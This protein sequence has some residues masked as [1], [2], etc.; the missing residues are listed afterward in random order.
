MPVTALTLTPPDQSW[1]DRD[2][3]CR[4]DPVLM[5]AEDGPGVERARDVCRA[6]PV[7]ACC[8]AWT[9]SLPPSKDVAGV[10]GGL[11]VE[12]RQ[13]ARR[14]RLRRRRGVPRIEHGLVLGVA[15][16]QEVGDLGGVGD[17]VVCGAH[18]PIFRATAPRVI[19][20][21]LSQL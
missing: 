17:R 6:C 4:L 5:D 11:T 13:R 15:G 18:R 21:R 10:A 14:A 7:W 8:R 20:R 12:E 3:P 1:M 9:L 19:S 16:E 2:L